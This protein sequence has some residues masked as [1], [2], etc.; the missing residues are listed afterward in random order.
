MARAESRSGSGSATTRS[1]PAAKKTQQTRRTRQL[2]THSFACT[3]AQCLT[4]SLTHSCLDDNGACPTSN[5]TVTQQERLLR[6]SHRGLA[7]KAREVARTGA[8]GDRHPPG[9]AGREADMVGQGVH[10]AQE[11]QRGKAGQ[12]NEGREDYQERIQPRRSIAPRPRG[13][14][15]QWRGFGRCFGSRSPASPGCRRPPVLTPVLF[16]KH[17]PRHPC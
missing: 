2:L 17:A 10:L 3:H 1:V 7:S 14:R 8:D 12:P 6:A 15:E 11:R 16:L 9:T 13:R 4:H 5:K